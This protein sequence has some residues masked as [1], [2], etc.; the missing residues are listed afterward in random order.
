MDKHTFDPERHKMLEDGGSWILKETPIWDYFSRPAAEAYN[1][2]VDEVVK[3]NTGITNQ[4]AI[5]KIKEIEKRLDYRLAGT[6]YSEDP[7]RRLVTERQRLSALEYLNLI[8]PDEQGVLDKLRHDFKAAADEVEQATGEDRIAIEHGLDTL[9]TYN[10]AQNLDEAKEILT[11]GPV[12][13]GFEKS[14]DVRIPDSKVNEFLSRTFGA[15]GL[16]KAQLGRVEKDD[17]FIIF[18]AKDRFDEANE[19]LQRKI[20]SGGG[21]VLIASNYDDYI[22]AEMFLEK[23]DNPAKV[24]HIYKVRATAGDSG[25]FSIIKMRNFATERPEDFDYL[26]DIDLDN[27]NK[28]RVY[29]LGTLAHEVAHRLED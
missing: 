24:K 15:A 10:M 9:L 6:T 19:L 26:N 3:A 25:G 5:E 2:L 21:G 17:N 27:D 1:K 14:K 23:V 13:S 12:V 4:Q 20:V 22:K 8:S 28:K 29:M 16:R 18:I 7:N 11:H